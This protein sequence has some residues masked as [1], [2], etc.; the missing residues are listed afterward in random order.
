MKAEEGS[1]SSP[2]CERRIDKAS[3]LVHQIPE[4]VEG[5]LLLLQAGEVVSGQ[6]IDRAPSCAAEVSLRCLGGLVVC[7]PTQEDLGSVPLFSLN[8]RLFIGKLGTVNL[9]LTQE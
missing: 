1:N 3:R 8:R 6:R 9:R 2:V 5:G 7:T 4:S